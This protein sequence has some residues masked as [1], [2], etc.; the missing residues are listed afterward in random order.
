M[1]WVKPDK[2]NDGFGKTRNLK[3]YY[4]QTALKVI[5]YNNMY[6]SFY[7]ALSCLLFTSAN[8]VIVAQWIKY[9]LKG[10]NYVQTHKKFILHDQ[11]YL[12]EIWMR[13]SLLMHI[14]Q[15]NIDTMHLFLIGT[16]HW[17]NVPITYM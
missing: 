11:L 12:G 15:T 17:L 14:R 1:I 4:V 7:D 9:I 2:N 10:G 6:C 8:Y 13:I 16:Q 3:K 5:I